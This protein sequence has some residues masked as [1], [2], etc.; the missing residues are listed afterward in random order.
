MN[1]I[2]VLVLLCSAQLLAATEYYENPYN[3]RYT[4]SL[5]ASMVTSY[6]ER[7]NGGLPVETTTKIEVLRIKD[8]HGTEIETQ[9]RTETEFVNNGFPVTMIHY[10]DFADE[11]IIR[12]ATDLSDDVTTS[13]VTSVIGEHPEKELLAIGEEWEKTLVEMVNVTFS[14]GVNASGKTTDVTR[15][16]FLGLE[17]IST[18]WG[19]LQAAKIKYTS[20]RSTKFQDFYVP[21]SKMWFGWGLDTDTVEV[22]MR[23]SYLITS[24]GV[25]YYLKGLGDYK[26]SGSQ[27]E[28]RLVLKSLNLRSQSRDENAVPEKSITWERTIVSSNFNVTPTSFSVITPTQH[29]STA[30]LDS[31][32][33]NGSFPWVYNA[34][35]D[36]WFYYRFN[37]NICY[38]YDVRSSKWFAFDEGNGGW[39]LVQ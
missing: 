29:S 30:Y 25:N 12:V 17:T 26:S 10:I 9:K 3:H 8:F 11:N 22:T 2:L 28:G 15:F 23:D 35:T 39:R 5:G 6:V 18:V 19:P 20:T 24:Q 31:W 36:S 37:G 7:E 33:W 13:R 32:T 27:T 4:R 1:K 21:H 38:A 16:T 14:D 34:N